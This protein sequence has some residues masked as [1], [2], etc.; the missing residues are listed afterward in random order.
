[1][2][3]YFKTLLTLL[4]NKINPIAVKEMRQAVRSRYITLL[5]QLYLLIELLMTGFYLL[6]IDI[7]DL[8]SGGMDLFVPLMILLFIANLICVP[9]YT[10]T[11]L[12]KEVR[13]NDAM[14]STTLTPMQIVRGKFLCGLFI[15]LLLFSAAAPFVILTYLLRGLD[16]SQILSTLYWSFLT[17]QVFNCYGIVFGALNI[18]KV[19][20]AI[21]GC[22]M[23]FAIIGF[24]DNLPYGGF[25]FISS[26]SSIDWESIFIVTLVFL[27]MG[28]AFMTLAACLLSPISYNR[29]TRPR[30]FATVSF[31]SLMIIAVLYHLFT[32]RDV[33]I[34]V[35]G[36]VV[37]IVT[38]AFLGIGLC[39]RTSLSVR[40]IQ[41]IPRSPV[42]R[43]LAFPFFTCVGSAIVW[44]ILMF[45]LLL[46]F[47]YLFN[48]SVAC[49]RLA[50]MDFPFPF[51]AM[52][53][54]YSTCGMLIRIGI[55]R[56]RRD[57]LSQ[58]LP[59]NPHIT[60]YPSPQKGISTVA[61]TMFLIAVPSLIPLLFIFS[62]GSELREALFFF[63]PFNYMDDYGPKRNDFIPVLFGLVSSAFLIIYSVISFLRYYSLGPTNAEPTNLNTA[64]KQGQ[65]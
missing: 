14:F 46:L 3:Q 54:F 23:G 30:I 19:L 26:V 37:F 36:A 63:S 13:E 6:T 21:I 9:V 59:D 58:R 65:I 40:Q 28:E 2:I 8:S 57:N 35:T 27:F 39:E 41:Q 42:L 50:D 1:M 29:M 18:N 64:S 49:E 4:D 52:I 45:G 51:L 32:L 12:A 33:Y 10:S 20:R 34:D 48:H 11:R 22:I 5:L 44:F 38:L 24:L 17:I 25:S 31:F 62:R 56:W 53:L 7:N 43:I 61:Y 16:I 15:S 60:I 47:D 55:D